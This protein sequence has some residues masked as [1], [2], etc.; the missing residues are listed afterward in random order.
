MET[1]LAYDMVL[2]YFPPFASLIPEDK[3]GV[4]PTK[5]FNTS[6]MNLQKI[7]FDTFNV[8]FNNAEKSYN[9][10]KAYGHIENN[11]KV[12]LSDGGYVKLDEIYKYYVNSLDA[13]IS[14][15]QLAT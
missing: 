1:S 5:G 7:L 6:K 11:D 12:I 4:S 10:Y 2:E 8:F 15:H 9:T 3:V 14:P 13:N